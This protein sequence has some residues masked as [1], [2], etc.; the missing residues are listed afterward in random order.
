MSYRLNT[1]H[2]EQIA[3]SLPHKDVSFRGEEVGTQGGVVFDS[4]W[5]SRGLRSVRLYNEV[6]RADFANGDHERYWTVIVSGIL[7]TNIHGQ[8]TRLG[9]C[10]GVHYEELP[11][12]ETEHIVEVEAKS[13]GD[14]IHHLMLTTDTGRRIHA[15]GP[16][17]RHSA[18]LSMSGCNVVGFYGSTREGV[19]SSLGCWCEMELG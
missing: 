15:G 11:L 14:A 3:H 4:R 8:E 5:P 12:G 1:T 6:S 19:L 18:V 2:T 16:C 17:G 9:G 7:V 10:S 13:W